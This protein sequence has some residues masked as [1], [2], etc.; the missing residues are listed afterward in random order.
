LLKANA[1]L[2]GA[3]IL[4]ALVT[5]VVRTKVLHLPLDATTAFTTLALFN[6]IR[7]PLDQLADQ[8]SQF[9]STIISCK[10]VDAL[11]EEEDTAKYAVLATPSQA[12]DPKI[13]FINA[14]FTWGDV[15]D[16]LAD[17]NVFKL[18]N[19]NLR[20]VLDGLNLVVGPVGSVSLAHEL[21]R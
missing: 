2:V 21:A 3:P 12:S 17:Q 6:V 13:G 4:I 11:L 7:A 15:E 14:G 19:L 9:L 10:R 18:Q 8:M 20:F 5:F 16:A 1:T